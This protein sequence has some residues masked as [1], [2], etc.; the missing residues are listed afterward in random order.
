MDRKKFI[1]SLS[2]AS[3]AHISSASGHKYMK[4]ERRDRLQ[5]SA[6]K[7]S[8]FRLA[9]ITDPHIYPKNQAPEKMA[10]ALRHIQTQKKNTSRNLEWWRFNNGCIRCIQRVYA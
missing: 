4:R 1:A 3:T 10:D 7:F 5:G 6:K 9:H 2:L 8:G